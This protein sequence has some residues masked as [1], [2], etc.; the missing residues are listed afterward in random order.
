MV[1]RS[2]DRNPL[3]TESGVVGMARNNTN[4]Q[5]FWKVCE[6]LTY[7]LKTRKGAGIPLL[8]VTLDFNAR[9]DEKS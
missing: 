4:L 1:I 7:C 9:C 5:T 6:V 8:V 2:F 3:V